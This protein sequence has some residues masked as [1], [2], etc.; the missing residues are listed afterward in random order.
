M[1]RLT[2]ADEKRATEALAECAAATKHIDDPKE[3]NEA[4]Y[5]VLSKRLGDKP[6]LLKRACEGYNS[7]KS[8]YRLGAATDDT[9]GNDFAIVDAPAL[10]KRAADEA[11]GRFISK[12]ASAAGVCKAQF[13]I[14]APKHSCISKTASA[15]EEEATRVPESKS[16]GGAEVLGETIACLDDMCY[17]LRK[18]ANEYKNTQSA[19]HDSEVRFFNS[20]DNLSAPMRKQASEVLHAYYGEVGDKLVELYNC[21][22]PMNK[23]ASYSKT[24]YKGS[25]AVPSDDVYEKAHD[26]LKTHILTKEASTI[27]EGF[28]ASAMSMICDLFNTHQSMRK[29]AAISLPV[30]SMGNEVL[31]KALIGSELVDNTFKLQDKKQS[32]SLEQEIN[33]TN[34]VNALK[35]HSVKRAFMHTA[36]DPTVAR[37]PLHQVTAAFN[38]ALAELPVH[39][40]SLPPS[41]F[42]ALIKSRTIARL[43]RGGAASASDVEQIQQI[44]QA[45]GRVRESDLLSSVGRGDE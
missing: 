20:M 44:Q 42:S 8:V 36:T 40:R 41:A 2:K 38:D 45:Y 4:V 28:A 13:A 25:V 37:Y 16:M 23:V 7:A 6:E 27:T 32:A 3:L 11:R 29:E 12:A 18:V 43:G 14:D 19:I 39:M 5:N 15:R 21:A 33:T 1:T 10:A 34:L 31:G 35:R 22:R 26:V 17:S 30:P 9:R 24:R